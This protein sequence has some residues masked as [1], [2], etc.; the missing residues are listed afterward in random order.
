[1]RLE[2]TLKY[3]TKNLQLA[4]S[5]QAYQLPSIPAIPTFENELVFQHEK[6]IR[7]VEY[8]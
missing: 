2:L 3:E 8:S 5:V 7:N 1:M 6:L 4:D